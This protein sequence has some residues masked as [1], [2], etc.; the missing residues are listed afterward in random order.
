[1][2]Q[3][4]IGVVM[5]LAGLIGVQLSKKTAFAAAAVLAFV[6]LTLALASAIT[7]LYTGITASISDPWLL[8]GLGLFVPSNAG[9]CMSAVLAAKLARRI[10]DINMT[11]V[12]VA[13]QA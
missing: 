6:A 5:F 11:G 3:G 10:Y 4:L 2:V 9:A 13:A 12:Q 1:M 8:Q 7:A